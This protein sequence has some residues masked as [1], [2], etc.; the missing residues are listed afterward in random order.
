M[1]FSALVEQLETRQLL[2]AIVLTDHQDYAP[3]STALITATTDGGPTHNFLPGETV[4]FQ[5]TRTDGVPD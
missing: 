1:Q 4:Q 3:G 5:V 2:S